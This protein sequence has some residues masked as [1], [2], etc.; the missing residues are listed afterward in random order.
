MVFFN[1]SLEIKI[2]ISNQKKTKQNKIYHYFPPKIF[3][4][5]SVWLL[6]FFRHLIIHQVFLL[7]FQMRRRNVVY[8]L[9]FFREE[10]E[11]LKDL[12]QGNAS[13]D[14]DDDD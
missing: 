9:N 3:S 1:I 6:L 11:E 8:P 7:R 10:E 2:Q 13:N 5:I 12:Q 4:V 14:K